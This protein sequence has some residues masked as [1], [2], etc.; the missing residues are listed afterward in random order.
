MV[1]EKFLTG[2][3]GSMKAVLTPKV[4]GNAKEGYYIIV[5]LEDVIDEKNE[6]VVNGGVKFI[7]GSK[8]QLEKIKAGWEYNKA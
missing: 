7:S 4:F 1:I 8:A 2:K 6:V 5:V 3:K